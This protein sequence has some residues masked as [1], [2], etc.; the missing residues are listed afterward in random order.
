MK[1]TK[2]LWITIL[3]VVF[4][5]CGSTK[6][7]PAPVV[8]EEPVIEEPAPVPV[9]V[10]KTEK[11]KEYERSVGDIDVSLD[12]FTQ[13]KN[14]ILA[15][16]DELAVVMKNYDYTSW[17]TYLDRE[18]I[19]YWSKRPNLSVAQKKLPVKNLQLRTLEDYFKHV[20]IPA[21]RGKKVTEIRYNSDKN[22]KAV[23]VQEDVD[24]VYYNFNKINNVWK[25]HIP[26]NE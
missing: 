15:I 18:S 5:S 25:V 19:S 24:I 1:L 20:F 3:A 23:Q 17:L 4:F 8:V 14:A 9:P 10:E 6:V 21:R 2:S 16:I 22:I 26:E 12:T 11:E 13:D 7:E